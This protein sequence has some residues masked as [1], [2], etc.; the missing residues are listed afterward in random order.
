MCGWKGNLSISLGSAAW[1]MEGCIWLRGLMCVRTEGWGSSVD[2]NVVAAAVC[3]IACL[4]E[5]AAF[6]AFALDEL[7]NRE[8]RENFAASLVLELGLSFS[9]MTS[10][11]LFRALLLEFVFELAMAMEL[12]M[13][14]GLE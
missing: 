10:D 9:F 7:P 14:F 11:D 13:E 3:R 1:M 4:A 6:L 5:L 2:V 12:A 8:D